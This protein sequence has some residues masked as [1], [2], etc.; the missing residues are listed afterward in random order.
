MSSERKPK[1]LFIGSGRIGTESLAKIANSAK[2]DFL[3]IVTQEDKPAGRKLQL[4]PTPVAEWACSNSLPVE[5]IR[6]VNDPDFVSKVRAMGTDIIFLAS[7]GQILKA[8]ILSAPNVEPLNL[9]ASLL[10][11]FRG[12]SPIQ[13]AII[14]GEKQAGISFMRMEKGLDTGPVFAKFAT[15][16]S[17]DEDSESLETKLACLAAQHVE[18]VILKI[19]KRELEP[20]PQDNSLATYA[21]KIEKSDGLIDWREDALRVER[22][23]RAFRQ[24]PGAFFQLDLDGKKQRVKIVRAKVCPEIQGALGEII[25]TDKKLI[26]VCGKAGIELER[27]IPEGRR[28]MDATEFLRGWKS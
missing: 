16:I 3:G 18:D 22:K 24:W 17:S 9:H 20:V 12:A 26:V 14:S 21:A 15:D 4:K 10:P 13:A 7:F 25:R 27:I 5:K 2:I 1:V 28:E 11:K 23:V 19:F 6:S 8:E